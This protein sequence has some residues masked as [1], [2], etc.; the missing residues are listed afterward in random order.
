M[1]EDIWNQ[2]CS[3]QNPDADKSYHRKSP[4]NGG[5]YKWQVENIPHRSIVKSIEIIRNNNT[6]L[7]RCKFEYDVHCYKNG[8]RRC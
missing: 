7:I 3:D 2:F 8:W 1:E 5:L 6:G 4:I